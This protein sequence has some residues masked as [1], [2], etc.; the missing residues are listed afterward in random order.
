VLDSGSIISMIKRYTLLPSV[1]TKKISAT[2]H[3]ATLAG[4]FK[5]QEIVILRDLRL[6]EFDKNR[7]TSKQK[8]LVFD[9]DKIKYNITWVLIS[10]QRQ[11]LN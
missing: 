1:I 10:S 7:C 8:A 6:P 5:A 4:K 3:F 9:N 11:E 2:K